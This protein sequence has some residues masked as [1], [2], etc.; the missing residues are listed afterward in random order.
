MWPSVTAKNGG[1]SFCVGTRERWADGVCFSLASELYL[2][3]HSRGSFV[4][5]RAPVLSPTDV[6]LRIRRRLISCRLSRSGTWYGGVDNRHPRRSGRKRIENSSLFQSCR[7]RDGPSAGNDFSDS[8]L[9]ISF[10]FASA[11]PSDLS[12]DCCIMRAVLAYWQHT[13]RSQ[14]SPICRRSNCAGS[15]HNKEIN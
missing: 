8:W 13:C 6:T 15:R 10:R 5:Q 11:A 9:A 7:C 3:S 1:Y 2:S 14:V 12:T 4:G